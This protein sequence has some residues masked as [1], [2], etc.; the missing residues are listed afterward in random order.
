VLIKSKWEEA[1]GKTGHRWIIL[2]AAV[3][4]KAKKKEPLARQ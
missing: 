2:F 3:A 1:G 4:A